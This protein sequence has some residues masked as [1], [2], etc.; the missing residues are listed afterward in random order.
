[1][2]IPTELQEYKVLLSATLAEVE[3]FEERQ[4]KACS[5]RIR[6]LSNQLGKDGKFLRKTLVELDKTK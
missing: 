4:T 2:S 5:A 6:K 1:M 3:N